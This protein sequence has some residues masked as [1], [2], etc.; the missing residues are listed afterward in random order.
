MSRIPKRGLTLAAIVAVAL[1]TSAHV[2]SPDTWYSGDAGPY[3]VLVHVRAPGVIPGVADVTVQVEGDEDVREVLA[4]VNRFDAVEA[5]PPPERARPVR[6]EPKAYRVSLWVMTGGS[7][8]FTVRVR[9]DRGEGVAV[10]PATIV[11]F[12]R[13]DFSGALAAGLG[14]IGVFLFAGAVSIVGSAVRESG[15]PAGEEPGPERRRAARIAMG[16]TAAVLALV[17]FGGKRWWDAEDRA[18][19]AS[20]FRPLQAK[21]RINETPNGRMLRFVISDTAWRQPNV[22]GAPGGSPRSRFTPLVPDHGKLMHLFAVRDDL[23]AIAHLHP[24]TSDTVTFTAPLPD[25]PSGRYRIYADITHESGYAQTLPAMLEVPGPPAGG[26][27]QDFVTGSS[28]DDSWFIGDPHL[29][30]RGGVNVF[31]LDRSRGIVMSRDTREAVSAG[32]PVRLQ[33]TVSRLDGAPVRLEPYMGMDA[34]AVIVRDD[35]GVFIHLHPMG[36]ISAASQLA[37]TLREPGD[38]VIGTLGQRLTAVDSAMASH[39]G[40]AEAQNVLSFPYAFPGSGRYAVWVQV[41]ESGRVLT[42]AFGLEVP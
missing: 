5:A 15:L 37:L 1:F 11:A 9:G 23:G 28:G 8:S 4:N 35:G 14:L 18:H 34:H 17:V 38:T 29:L 13:L 27:P 33:F 39:A 16:I 22:S 12:R 42:G 32:Q 40:H 20:M 36:T 19:R 21:A 31:P 24:E 10:V 3:R 6:G 41:R 26:L 30:S 25:L 7:N 2:G